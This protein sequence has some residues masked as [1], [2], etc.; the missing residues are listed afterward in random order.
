MRVSS[1]E[2]WLSFFWLEAETNL[3]AQGSGLCGAAGGQ[4]VPFPPLGALGPSRGS[5]DGGRI[6]LLPTSPGSPPPPRP[7]PR[8]RGAGVVAIRRLPSRQLGV[9]WCGRL[10]SC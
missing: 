5:T 8:E 7:L 3:C 2:W 9:C 10:C 4:A 1:E 6:L